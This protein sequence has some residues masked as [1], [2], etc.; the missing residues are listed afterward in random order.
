MLTYALLVSGQGCLQVRIRE[1]LL[2]M[3][4][5]PK[6]NESETGEETSETGYIDGR[7]SVLKPSSV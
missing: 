2:A 4:H 6:Q 7:T 3:Q 5:H 1:E